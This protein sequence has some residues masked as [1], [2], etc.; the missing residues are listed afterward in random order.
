M[1]AWLPE[2]LEGARIPGP[3]DPPVIVFTPS[4]QCSGGVLEVALV[5]Q[6]GTV[7]RLP[8]I[9]G[10]ASV[11]FTDGGLVIRAGHELS[12]D[13]NC[14]P[15]VIEQRTLRWIGNAAVWR[16]D[17]Q[18]G[19]LSAEQGCWHAG[20]LVDA[21]NARWVDT[22][23]VGLSRGELQRRLFACSDDPDQEARRVSPLD[24]GLRI[25]LDDGSIRIVWNATAQRWDVH[26]E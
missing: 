10:V 25:A 3:D 13:A 9:G 20:R 18:P 12:T 5:A 26:A 2:L 7:E 17:Y 1:L 4:C 19:Q 6:D 8:F 22:S 23:G 15:S 11:R 24:K 14:C 21:D 16:T